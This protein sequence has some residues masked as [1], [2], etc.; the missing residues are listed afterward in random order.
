MEARTHGRGDSAGTAGSL[1][2]VGMPSVPLTS[3]SARSDT[4]MRRKMCGRRETMAILA[5][6]WR[7]LRF[8][9]FVGCAARLQAI[10]FRGVVGKP[11]GKWRS[12]NFYAPPTSPHAAAII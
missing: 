2:F 9:L 1:P 7:I 6:K 8:V 4:L 12:G 5:T 3:V 10:S 11:K